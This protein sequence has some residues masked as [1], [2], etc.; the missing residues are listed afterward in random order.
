MLTTLAG[1]GLAGTPETVPPDA[2]TIASA[3]S[4]VLPPHCASTRMG[5]IFASYA[6]P[7]TPLPLLVAAAMVPATC[8]PC[9]LEFWSAD[10]TGWP[11]ESVPQSPFFIQ[12]PL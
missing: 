9:Q 6:M 5:W 8:V 4:E 1:V 3:M 7:A 11:S 12:S 10:G 2:H